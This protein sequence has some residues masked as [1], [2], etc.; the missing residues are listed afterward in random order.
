MPHQPEGDEGAEEA[1][2]APRRP[3]DGDARSRGARE[4]LLAEEGEEHEYAAERESERR[5]GRDEGAHARVTRHVPGTFARI[6]EAEQIDEAG[7]GGFARLAPG[8]EKLA[9]RRLVAFRAP[10]GKA[11]QEER[12]GDERGG[13]AQEGRVATDQREDDAPRRRADRD[14]G[15][16]DRVLQRAGEDQL[17]AG[18]EIRHRRGLRGLE[19]GRSDRVRRHDH[20]DDPDL[21]GRAHEKQAEDEGRAQ[22]IA[23]DED[24]PPRDPV[25][26]HAS[27]RPQ[28]EE[29]NEAGQVHERDRFALPGQVEEQGKQ[30]DHVEPVAHLRDR[31]CGVEAAKSGVAPHYTYQARQCRGGVHGRARWHTRVPSVTQNTVG[32]GGRA[33]LL[34]G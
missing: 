13:V 4:D 29:R 1:A 17:V 18:D 34:C 28:Q 11:S 24:G 26:E 7:R 3:Q 33:L 19:E 16:P 5:D 31:I 30:R 14:G 27:W 2:D 12:R 8:S 25:G 21:L 22:H 32:T 9:P 6:G 20:V 15:A 23:G 10:G